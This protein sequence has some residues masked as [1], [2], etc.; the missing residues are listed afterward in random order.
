MPG[1]TFVWFRLD[2]R[3]YVKQSTDSRKT[4]L[5]NSRAGGHQHC[6]VCLRKPGRDPMKAVWWSLPLLQAHLLS[7]YHHHIPLECYFDGWLK[8]EVVELD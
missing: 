7:D 3:F 1:K 4:W 6:E 2:E 8:P 5:A